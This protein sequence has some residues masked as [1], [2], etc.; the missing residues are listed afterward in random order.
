MTKSQKKAVTDSTYSIQDGDSLSSIADNK[1]ISV[2]SIQALN[3]DIDFN[4]IYPG[5]VIKI[6]ASTDSSTAKDNEG[7]GQ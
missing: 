7:V 6:P 3:P 1:G 4:L 5:Q 2:E